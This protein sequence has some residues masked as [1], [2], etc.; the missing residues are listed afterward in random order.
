MK[1][2]MLEK[3]DNREGDEDEDEDE[4]E[5]KTNCYV[6]ECRNLQLNKSADIRKLSIRILYCYFKAG[7]ALGEVQA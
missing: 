6:L 1:S 7:A 5:E 2:F 4:D 3:E